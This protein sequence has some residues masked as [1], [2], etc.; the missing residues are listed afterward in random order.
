MELAKTNGALPAAVESAMIDGDLSKLNAEQRVAYYNRICESVGLNPLTQPFAYIVLNGKLR[1]YA[2]K[3]CTEQLR[4]IH[5]VSVKILNRERTDDLCIVTAQARK[6]DGREDEGT[7]AVSLI[8]LKGEA[9]ANALMKTETKAKRRVTLSICG[10]GWLDESEVESV[11]NARVV[12]ANWQPPEGVQRLEAIG[13]FDL[14]MFTPEQQK[15]LDDRFA[16][17][18]ADIRPLQNP[19]LHKRESGKRD[20]GKYLAELDSSKFGRARD[21]YL[22][23]QISATDCVNMLACL[24]EPHLKDYALETIAI[25]KES[26]DNEQRTA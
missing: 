25:E 22:K 10:L 6:P 9:L 20:V 19:W 21:A 24:E 2:K 26:K 14:P 11:N 17:G 13:A 4:E 15:Q 18:T 16:A 3:D 12:D 23:G 8:G 1:L 5:K 7:G